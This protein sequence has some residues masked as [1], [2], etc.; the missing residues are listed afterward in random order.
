MLSGFEYKTTGKLSEKPVEDSKVKV[1]GGKYEKSQL[2]CLKCGAG[3]LIQI[4]LKSDRLDALAKKYGIQSC[5]WIAKQGTAD[6]ANQ[7]WS[8]VPGQHF[9]SFPI[10]LSLSSSA[11][12]RT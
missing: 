2:E 7:F 6:R 1:L 5:R 3:E 8:A 10:F 9:H 12:G 4:G 11:M